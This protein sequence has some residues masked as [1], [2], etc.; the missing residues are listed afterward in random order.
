MK[1]LFLLNFAV[2]F[3]I[4]LGICTVVFMKEIVVTTLHVSTGAIVLALS[5]L[6][7]L[8]SSPIGWSGFTKLLKSK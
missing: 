1:T 8:R 2:A 7:V 4:V 3:Q 5:F 6:L